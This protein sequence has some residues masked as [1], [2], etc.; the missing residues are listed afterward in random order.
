LGNLAAI[1][2]SHDAPMVAAIVAAV[3]AGQIVVA[4]DPSDPLSRLRVLVEDAEPSVIV[5]DAANL[6]LA[7][8]FAPPGC[9]I[10]NFELPASIGPVENPSLVIPPG[11][12]AVLT[13]TSGSTGRPKG[14]MRTHQ[15]ISRAAA[16]HTDAMQSTEKDRI[17][18]FASISTAQGMSFLW[19]ILLNGAT[20]CPF[21]VKTKGITGFVNW[22]GDLGR[23]V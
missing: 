10:L 21:P 13:Y 19:W 17:T 11:Q 3:K 1:L 6:N 8:E 15:Q 7:A 20:V 18:L 4:L 9:N 14:V 2:M 16:I 22:F 5:T 23:T 12:T